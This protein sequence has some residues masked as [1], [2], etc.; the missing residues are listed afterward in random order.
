MT[1]L[2]LWDASFNQPVPPKFLLARTLACRIHG[3]QT[4]DG[5]QPYLD[6]IVA[7]ANFVAAWKDPILTLVAVLHDS[8]ERAPDKGWVAKA[9]QKSMP[10]EVW[11]AM[12]PL[13]RI[14]GESYDDHLARVL[15]GGKVPVLVK[16]AEITDNMR[17][18]RLNERALE[19]WALVRHERYREAQHLLTTWL[20]NQ[21]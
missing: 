3:P 2:R 15:D 8:I 10:N 9:I 11:L 1:A 19:S 20:S 4:D 17:I 21:G 18:N 7:V 14:M 5:G 6:H 16:L 12:G 13:T